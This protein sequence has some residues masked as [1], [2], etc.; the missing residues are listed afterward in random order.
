MGVAMLKGVPPSGVRV[1]PWSARSG[2]AV[3]TGVYRSPRLMRI[4]M[5]SIFAP[6]PLLKSPILICAQTQ[7]K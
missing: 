4:Y 1:A 3:W 7:K 5:L 2:R 6:G